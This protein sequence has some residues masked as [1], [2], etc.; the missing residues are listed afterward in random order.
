MSPSPWNLNKATA[1]PNEW[2]WHLCRRADFTCKLWPGNRQALYER[3]LTVDEAMRETYPDWC[4]PRSEPESRKE[5]T[6][7]E[8]ERG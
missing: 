3:G 7:G 1:S 2:E 6:D 8:S 5:A 4:P